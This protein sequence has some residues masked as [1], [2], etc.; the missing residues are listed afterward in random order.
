MPA[1]YIQ[2]NNDS[3]K[4][5]DSA[6]HKIICSNGKVFILRGCP[7]YDTFMKYIDQ[8]EANQDAYANVLSFVWDK[9]QKG[10]ETTMYDDAYMYDNMTSYDSEEALDLRYLTMEFDVSLKESA[11]YILDYSRYYHNKENID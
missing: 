10:V 7:I 2:K 5:E 11:N 9:I 8:M 3:L 1:L 6:N 4:I